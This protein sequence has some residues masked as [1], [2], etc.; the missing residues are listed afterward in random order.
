MVRN[1]DAMNALIHDALVRGD[2][3]Q[4]ILVNYRGSLLGKGVSFDTDEL[5]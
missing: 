2:S 5:R 3:P 4:E 1:D